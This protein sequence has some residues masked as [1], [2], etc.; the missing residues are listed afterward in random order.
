MDRTSSVSSVASFLSGQL[1][2]ETVEQLEFEKAPFDIMEEC[3][4]EQLGHGKRRRLQRKCWCLEVMKSWC[5]LEIMKSLSLST[6]CQK[7]L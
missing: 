1:H 6:Q 3:W 5:S 7:L 4:R 2:E